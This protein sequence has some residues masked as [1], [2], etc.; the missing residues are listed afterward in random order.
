MCATDGGDIKVGFSKF[1]G[2]QNIMCEFQTPGFELF[3]LFDFGCALIRLLPC[4]DSS[5]GVRKSLTS[6]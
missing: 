6:F 3:T 5:L 4:L 2:T 1:P